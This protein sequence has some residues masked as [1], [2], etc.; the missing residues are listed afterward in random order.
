MTT[1]SPG[2]LK[3][4]FFFLSLVWNVLAFIL[5]YNLL[6]LEDY[7]RLKRNDQ[8]RQ[9]WPYRCLLKIFLILAVHAP[10]DEKVRFVIFHLV[11]CA[12]LGLFCKTRFFLQL[13]KKREYFICNVACYLVVL[14]C[15]V[16][17]SIS[18][19]KLRIAIKN[20][21]KNERERDGRSLK[22]HSGQTQD[23]FRFIII[24]I[25][26]FFLCEC[27]RET[28]ERKRWKILNENE[29]YDSRICLPSTALL[30]CRA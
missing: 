12:S 14:F 28:R 8:Q 1:T 10:S 7:D 4:V 22:W 13:S 19:P 21:Q 29:F 3:Q 23:T 2:I 6:K 17:M 15:F 20:I 24:I 27:C 16:R 5:P 9:Q 26:I 18:L 25:S 11:F 30:T